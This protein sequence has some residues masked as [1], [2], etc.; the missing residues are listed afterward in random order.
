[1]R[2]CSSD[3]AA[4]YQ[5]RLNEVTL[6]KIRRLEGRIAASPMVDTAP[7]VKKVAA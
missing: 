3:C 5:R 1:M 6:Q 7:A 2:F 4:G